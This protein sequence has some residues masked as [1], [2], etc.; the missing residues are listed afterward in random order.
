MICRPKRTAIIR[1]DGAIAAPSGIK[2]CFAEQSVHGWLWHVH[3]VAI[4]IEPFT[5]T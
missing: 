4:Q 2:K 1:H 5:A 3:C